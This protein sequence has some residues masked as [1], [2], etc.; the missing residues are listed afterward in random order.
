MKIKQYEKFVQTLPC[1]RWGTRIS[2]EKQARDVINGY[3]KDIEILRAYAKK[4][5]SKIEELSKMLEELE[6]VRPIL[7]AADAQPLKVEEKE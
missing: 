6:R 1:E 2:S 7:E 5:E 4:I 3:K